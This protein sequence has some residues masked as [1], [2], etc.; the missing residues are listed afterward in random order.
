MDEQHDA[1]LEQEQIITE[2]GTDDEEYDKLL[3]DAL[4][5]AENGKS[6]LGFETRTQEDQQMDTE[7][8]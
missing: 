5:Q 3:V 7:M 1:T 8:G 6:S 4:E 2:Y